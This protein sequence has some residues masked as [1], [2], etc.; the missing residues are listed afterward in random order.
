MPSSTWIMSLMAYEQPL[1]MITHAAVASPQADTT[2]CP[3]LSY[4]AATV[5]IL[6]AI[7]CR[8]TDGPQVRTSR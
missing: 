6:H 7:C 1:I 2:K 8:D 3:C 5:H 4:N